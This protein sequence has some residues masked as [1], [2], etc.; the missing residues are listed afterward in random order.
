M[1][2]G[3]SR[4]GGD[5]GGGLSA[6]RWSPPD[7]RRLLQLA[8]AT[9]WLLDGVL[10]LQPFMFTAGPKGFGGMLAEAAV[11]NPHIVAH[12]I[13]SNANFVD[14]HAVA[15]NSGFALIQILV[16]F[17][18]AWRPTVKPALAASVIWSFGVWWFGE[19]LGGVLHGAASPIVG[20]PGAVL[21]Y[22]VLAVV[23][24]PADHPGPTTPFI[25]AGAIGR[26]AASVVWVVV[27]AGMGVL[28]LI[29]SGRSPQGVEQAIQSVNLGE[30]GWLARLDSHAASLVHG[31]GLTVAIVMAVVFV[32][33]AAGVFLPARAA[34]VT[35]VAAIVS[36]TVIW[37]VDRTSA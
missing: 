19:G 17:G 11:G 26:R 22:A 14:H 12:S 33:V 15:A 3:A 28:A 9:I 27:W 8:L 7:G 6:V 34:R 35:L 24:W 5:H 29:G 36:A 32:L 25:A 1:D 18:I 30:P 13:A 2:D 16:G 21:F 23:L 37:V 4:A 20:G 31:A 10:Q